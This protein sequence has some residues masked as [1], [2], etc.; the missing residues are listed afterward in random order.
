MVIFWK[1]IPVHLKKLYVSTI[2]HHSTPKEHQRKSKEP[3]RLIIDTNW[4]GVLNFAILCCHCLN[5]FLPFWAA[6]FNLFLFCVLDLAS[7]TFLDPTKL[8]CLFTVVKECANWDPGNDL[9]RLDVL[10]SLPLKLSVSESVILFRH[11]SVSSTYP[12]K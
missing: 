4:F 2:L 10:A 12:C 7:P 8:P 1:F 3:D 6:R 11:A 5:E 9:L